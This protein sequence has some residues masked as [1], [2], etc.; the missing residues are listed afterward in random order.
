MLDARV[1]RHIM[2]LDK[3]GLLH[4]FVFAITKDVHTAHRLIMTC[5]WYGALPSGHAII[6]F[7]L[8]L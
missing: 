1:M 5:A 3:F 2:P 4:E 8:L 7:H 6:Q